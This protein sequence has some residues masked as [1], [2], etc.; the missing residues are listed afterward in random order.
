LVLGTLPVFGSTIYNNLGPS[1]SFLTNRDYK[2]NFDFLATTFVTTGGGHLGTIMTPIFS[3]NPPGLGVVFFHLNAC[4]SAD[5]KPLKKLE[6][7]DQGAALLV[8]GAV[9]GIGRDGASHPDIVM[10]V[11]SEIVEAAEADAEPGN[12]DAVQSAAENG[13][14]ELPTLNQ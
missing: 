13:I 11:T 10:V 4:L 6:D 9:Q 14:T 8:L 2:T 1:N 7:S 12:Q 5:V 3:L